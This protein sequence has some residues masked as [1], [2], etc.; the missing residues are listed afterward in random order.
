MSLD[1]QGPGTGRWDS[2]ERAAAQAALD[3][4][5][6]RLNGELSRTWAE[7]R[8]RRSQLRRQ[9]IQLRAQ[10]Q[11]RRASAPDFDRRAAAAILEAALSVSG[12]TV[13]QLWLDYVALGGSATRAELAAMVA[14]AGPIDRLDHDRIVSALNERLDDGGFGRPLAYWDGS[15]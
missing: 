3:E 10:M 1:R 15:R 13:S 14:G 2:S 4:R 8:V 7:A 11:L 12:L 6:R 9:R 5:L